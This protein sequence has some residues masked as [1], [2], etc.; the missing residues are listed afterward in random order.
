MRRHGRVT[1]TLLLV[2]AAT[3]MTGCSTG[4]LSDAGSRVL[5]ITP[6]LATRC[7]YRGNFTVEIRG[8]MDYEAA[9]VQAMNEARNK[10]AAESH[11][12]K[13]QQG[14]RRTSHHECR[15]RRLMPAIPHLTLRS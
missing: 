3:H 14:A 15:V 2:T 10:Q 11:K 5:E 1:I 9:R 8:D 4:E 13:M 6:E 12:R 7:D